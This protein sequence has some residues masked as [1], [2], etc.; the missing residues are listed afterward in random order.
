MWSQAALSPI[1]VRVQIS[2]ALR[3]IGRARARTL[4]DAAV[5][6]RNPRAMSVDGALI[7]ALPLGAVRH[8]CLHPG[9]GD[10]FSARAG[11]P[12]SPPDGG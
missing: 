5:Q 9:D 1:R 7:N 6:A 4:R 12:R 2:A 10:G 11:W 8:L 3:H